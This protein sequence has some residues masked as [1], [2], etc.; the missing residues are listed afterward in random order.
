MIFKYALK[1]WKMYRRINLI[2]FF[3]L[4]FTF[5]IISLCTSA[6]VPE[7]R[8]FH[9]ISSCYGKSGYYLQ[10][11]FPECPDQMHLLQDSTELKHFLKNAEVCGY[12]NVD[13]QGIEAGESNLSV[14]IR[15]YDETIVRDFKPQIKNGKWIDKKE[16]SP[17]GINAVIS[18]NR[19]GIETGDIIHVKIIVYDAQ[20]NG[21]IFNI[22]VTV[23]GVLKESSEIYGASLS[24]RNGINYKNCYEK[25]AAKSD[26][27]PV[28]LISREK[29]LS[30]AQQ[31]GISQ[32]CMYLTGSCFVMYHENISD[33]E[34]EYNQS[35]IKDYCDVV[36]MEELGVMSHNNRICLE[37]KLLQLS[38]VTIGAMIFTMLSQISIRA[39]VT[40]LQMHNYKLYQLCGMRKRQCCYINLLS[41][42]LLT[43]AAWLMA[44]VIMLLF[45][46]AALP[47]LNFAV[48]NRY[49]IGACIVVMMINT[50]VSSILPMITIC[51][52]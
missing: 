24:S 31:Q 49:Q 6:V 13:N 36:I 23:T 35:Y 12:S 5:F 45:K 43:G 17:D 26:G 33:K 20:R 8:L 42:M 27:N 28:L 39:I 51:K 18:E 3:Q 41:N 48:V 32:V 1:E 22:P 30:K 15:A 9:G 7:L 10:T 37:E 2:V 40:N 11:V 46:M 50:A 25:S 19:Y 16:L 4:I 52:M 21:A 14:D 47:D 29:L 44:F 38:P 34:K